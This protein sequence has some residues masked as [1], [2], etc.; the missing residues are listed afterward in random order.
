MSAVGS[1]DQHVAVWRQAFSQS[2]SRELQFRSQ[3]MATIVVGLLGLVISL[4]PVL[5]LF[6][7]T[8]DVKGWTAGQA[9]A[10][11]GVY[12]VMASVLAAFITPNL[13]RM[14]GYVTRGDL[15]Q[16]LVRPVSSQLYVTARWFAPAELIGVASGVV[17]V[18]VGLVRAGIAPSPLD[19]LLAVLWLAIGLL[20][21]TCLW[22]NL[23]YLEFWF[24][25]ADPIADLMS[26]LL[27]AGRYPIAF[28]PRAAQVLLMVVVPVGVATTVPVRALTGAFDVAWLPAGIGGLAVALVLTRLHWN[29]A[30][31]KYSSASS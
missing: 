27:G 23:A 13:G 14:H 10:L 11:V 21:V 12:Q 9:V 2:V 24:Q 3:A 7:F 20:L 17:V 28:F 18:V 16:V 30:L 22:S 26:D 25:A 5:L 6:T 1:R 8:P 15:D 31:R 4:L 19:A 29:A